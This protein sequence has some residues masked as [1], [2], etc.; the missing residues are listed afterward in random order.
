M[1]DSSGDLAS[2]AGVEDMEAEFFPAASTKLSHITT[3]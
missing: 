2:L 3:K 1:I